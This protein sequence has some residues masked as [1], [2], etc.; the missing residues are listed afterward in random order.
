MDGG[1]SNMMDFETGLT[2][3]NYNLLVTKK[4]RCVRSM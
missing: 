3:L 2:S 1:T 4:V